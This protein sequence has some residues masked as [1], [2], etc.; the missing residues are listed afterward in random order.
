VNPQQTLT[1]TGALPGARRR[2]D[3]DEAL[4]VLVVD[5]HPA[6]RAGLRGLIAAEPDLTMV[7]AAATAREGL[8]EAAALAPRVAIVD[9]RLPDHDGL[10]LTRRL[11]ALPEPPGVLVYSAYADP[12]MVIR[13]IVAGADGVV[14]KTAHGDR[15]CEAVRSIADGHAALPPV[16][17]TA[18]SRIARRLDPGD[19][20]ILGMLV[21]GTSPSEIAEVLAIGADWLEARRWAILQ[22]LR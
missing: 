1:T 20:P 7:A 4:R 17:P 15:I 2:E 21:H 14:A 3:A 10:T 12:T 8:A 13:A 16:S 5:D 11:K 6:V 22:Q 19:T 9:H 18:L